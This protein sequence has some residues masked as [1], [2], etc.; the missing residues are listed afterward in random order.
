MTSSGSSRLI[1]SIPKIARTPA[2]NAVSTRGR[3]HSRLP[4]D[5]PEPIPST[6]DTLACGLSSRSS[7]ELKL[8]PLARSMQ[9]IDS[10]RLQKARSYSSTLD[11]NPNGFLV[12]FQFDELVR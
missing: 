10:E 8:L 5:G 11:S 3:M 7:E 12:R 6:A 4:S 1:V 2:S 9:P